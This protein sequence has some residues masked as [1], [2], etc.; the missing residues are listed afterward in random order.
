MAKKKMEKTFET[1]GKIER[2]FIAGD[3]IS[4]YNLDSFAGKTAPSS[5][6]GCVDIRKYKL[7]IEP[8]IESKEVLIERLIALY[9]ADDAIA[10]DL[11]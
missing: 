2:V 7:T 11:R 3:I 4:S 5:F 6:N 10:W 8:I 1:Q 9:K